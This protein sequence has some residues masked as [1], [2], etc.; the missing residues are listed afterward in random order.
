MK[1]KK[2]LLWGAGL[3]AIYAV[4]VVVSLFFV[5]PVTVLKDKK[6][7][8]TIQVKDWQGNYHPLVVGPK[9]RY[10]TPLSQ[11]P[12]EMKWAV[13]LA[14][15]ASFYKHEGIDVKAIKEA[16]K[17]DLEKQSF[18]R[19]ASTITQQVAKNLFLSREKTLTRKAKELYLAKRMEQEIT[20]G[21]IIELYLNVIELGPM[22]HGIGHGARYYFGKSPAALTP[23]EC[24]FLAAMLPGPRVAYNP[25]K[26]LDKVLKRSNMILRL[27]A[28]KGVLSSGEYQAALAEMPNIGRMQKKVDESIKQVEVMANHT[29]A[30]VPQGLATEPEKGQAEPG[31]PP[32]EQHPAAAEPAPEKPQEGAA[33]AKEGAPAQD[34]Q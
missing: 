9:N 20:K 29:S 22:V 27:L 24:A 12:S 13:I 5:P 32:A 17:Y 14:E 19:G 1:L 2:Y 30:T 10:W 33:P 3:C 28:N 25:Y 16:I 11:I 21:R 6:M 8:M 15:D 26:N 34:K 18:A 31:A 4:Y 23:R 7:N